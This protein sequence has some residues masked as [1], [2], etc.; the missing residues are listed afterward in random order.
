MSGRQAR[1]RG[2]LR[3]ENARKK[4]VDAGKVVRLVKAGVER[5]GVEPGGNFCVNF[6]PIEQR[7]LRARRRSLPHRHR[8]ALHQAVGVLARDALLR[9]RQHHALRIVQAA[10]Q[11]EIA[12]HGLWIDNEFLDDVGQPMQGEIEMDRDVRA[13]TAL[14][15]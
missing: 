1:A 6:E 13:D 3:A 5:F 2:Q 14:D 8:I 11:R 9:Q 15:A 10:E 4:L 7:R 12:R